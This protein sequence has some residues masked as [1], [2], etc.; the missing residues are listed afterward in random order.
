MG[1]HGSL[2]QDGGYLAHDSSSWSP[3]E[4]PESLKPDTVFSAWASSRTDLVALTTERYSCF[5]VQTGSDTG[6]AESNVKYSSLNVCL[7][8]NTKA[9]AFYPSPT[10]L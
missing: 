2:T 6:R 8:L 7:S 4:M 10:G 3:K 5:K 1:A 9:A